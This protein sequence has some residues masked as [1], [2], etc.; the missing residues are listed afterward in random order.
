MRF[1]AVATVLFTAVVSVFASPVVQRD[2]PK[3]AA[4]VLTD[5][6]NTVTPLAHQLRE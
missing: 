3:S 6:S 4:V 2:T 5:L 1:F